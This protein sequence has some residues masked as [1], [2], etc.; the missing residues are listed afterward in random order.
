M[1]NLSIPSHVNSQRG[2]GLAAFGDGLSKYGA[3]LNDFQ[4]L[5]GVWHL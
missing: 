1:T 5:C 3:S 2:S 4:G